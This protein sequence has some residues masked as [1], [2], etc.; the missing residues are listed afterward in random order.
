MERYRGNLNK[1]LN[2]STWN[3]FLGLNF[4]EINVMFHVE[5]FLE[6]EILRIEKLKRFTWNISFSSD[7]KVQNG[8]SEWKFRMEV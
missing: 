7:L 4:E 1:R 5:R 8:S 3:D 6:F 2:R